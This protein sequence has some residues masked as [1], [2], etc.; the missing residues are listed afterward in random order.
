M[1]GL[2]S[3]GIYAAGD[4]ASR[5]WI[6]QP[7]EHWQAP[8]RWW[9]AP[10]VH[11]SLWHLLA[12]L[13]ACAV[14]VAWGLAARAQATQAMAWAV[15][16]P[17][18]M[19]LLISDPN[20]LPYAG[21]SIVL[22]AGVVVVCWQLMGSPRTRLRWIG[23][24]MLVAVGIKLIL[25]VPLLGAPSPPPLPGGSGQVLAAHAHACGAAAGLLS[26]LLIDGIIALMRMRTRVAQG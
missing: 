21:L 18:S 12:N 4:E 22:H 26:A 5:A 13:G 23:A 9:T 2:A 19:A 7:S 1:L 10:L 24:A 11:W 17:M 16:W 6:W 20:P 25:E 14:T 15:S 8:W 3:L